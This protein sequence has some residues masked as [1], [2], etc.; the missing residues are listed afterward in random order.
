MA[1][2]SSDIKRTRN[3]MNLAEA[4]VRDNFFCLQEIGSDEEQVSTNDEN[5][6]LLHK[7]ICSLE[8]VQ[9][10]PHKNQQQILNEPTSSE[11]YLD[12]RVHFAP[13]RC[14]CLT[15]FESWAIEARATH[16]TLHLLSIK[17]ASTKQFQH[18]RGCLKLALFA[19]VM[20]SQPNIS[21]TTLVGGEYTKRAKPF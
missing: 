18:N 13:L 19:S 14:L 4:I 6:A 3:A 1:Q 21:P 12:N 17:L 11:T 5:R 15:S 8:H 2:F 7:I 9:P 10:I 20:E 16:S